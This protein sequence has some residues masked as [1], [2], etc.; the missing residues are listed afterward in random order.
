MFQVG[1][2]TL[3]VSALRDVHWFSRFNIKGNAGKVTVN[4]ADKNMLIQRL[5]EQ[6]KMT[7]KFYLQKRKWSEPIQ[8]ISESLSSKCCQRNYI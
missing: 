2:E 3:S 1:L 6:L 5:L 8:A 7:P 4:E